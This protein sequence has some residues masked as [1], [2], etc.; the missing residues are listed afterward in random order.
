MTADDILQD[1]QALEAEM[2]V[3]EQ[4]YGIP[5]EAFYASYSSGEEPPDDSWVRDWT[6]WASGYQLLL[7]RRRQCEVTDSPLVF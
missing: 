4:R 3:Y 7:R 2:R 1:I 5:S 6:A